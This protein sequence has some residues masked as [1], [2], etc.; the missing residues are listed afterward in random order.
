[1]AKHFINTTVLLAE[2]CWIVETL[3]AWVT[4]IA[5]V[6][7]ICLFFAR[8]DNLCS[9]DDNN[10][11][12]TIYVRCEAWFVLSADKFCNFRAEATYNLIAGVNYD[13]LFLCCFLVDGNG[14]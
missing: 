8:E 7:L 2:I 11:V 12:S 5:S 6:N 9:V 13:P 1:M 4:S 3:T 10:I 14:L